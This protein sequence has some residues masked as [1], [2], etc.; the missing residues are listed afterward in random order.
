MRCYTELVQIEWDLEK[1]ASNLSKHGVS[2]DEAVSIFGDP[3]ATTVAD[4]E[5]SINEEPYSPQG[6]RARDAC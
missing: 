1:A 6:C 3:L 5:H 2:F 4:P